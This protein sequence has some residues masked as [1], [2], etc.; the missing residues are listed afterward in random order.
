[1]ESLLKNGR[2]ISGEERGRI[3]KISTFGKERTMKI[4]KFP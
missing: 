1:L 4:L 3:S 2:V